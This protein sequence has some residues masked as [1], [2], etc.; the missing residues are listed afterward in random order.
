MANFFIPFDGSCFSIGS[1]DNAEQFSDASKMSAPDKAALIEKIENNE[2]M[3]L[4]VSGKAFGDKPN[5]RM[6]RPSPGQMGKI[7]SKMNGIPFIKQHNTYSDDTVI[8]AV[9]SGSVTKENGIEEVTFTATLRQPDAM[10]KYVRG[11]IQQL[12][13]RL[14]GSDPHCSICGAKYSGNGWFGGLLCSHEVGSEYEN[15]KGTKDLCEVFFENPAPVELSAVVIGAYQGARIYCENGET[16]MNKNENSIAEGFSKPDEK[17]EEP[18]IDEKHVEKA[19][20][21]KAE[22]ID[23]SMAAELEAMRKERDEANSKLFDAMFDNAVIEHKV[24]PAQREFFAKY[25]KM[26][27]VK[28]FEEFKASAPAWSTLGMVGSSEENAAPKAVES[29][30]KAKTS[31]VLEVIEYGEKAGL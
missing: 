6:C 31:T 3:A 28:F 7:A 19:S 24:L 16:R 21:K 15:A 5:S 14:E 9:E 10:V 1:A 2:V 20:E 22:T 27:G 18:K 11:L 8:G 25:C 4:K 17:K 23:V 12:S 30:T 29:K 13:V 26:N